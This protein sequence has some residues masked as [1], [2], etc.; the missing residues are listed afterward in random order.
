V[1]R[2]TPE[3]S[4]AVTTTAYV[5]APPDEATAL[6]RRLVEERLAA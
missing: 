6:A 4:V 1:I 2:P 3:G 5:T